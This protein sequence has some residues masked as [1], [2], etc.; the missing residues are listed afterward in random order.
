[1]KPNCSLGFVSAIVIFAL[2]APAA[3]AVVIATSKGAGADAEVRDHQPATNLGTS[4]ELGT[5]ILDNVPPGASDLNDRFSAMYMKF[6]ITGQTAFANQTTSVR[7]TYRNSNLTP[8]R[9]HDTTPPGNNMDFRTGLAFY[10]L[11]RDHPGNN[12]SEATITYSNAPGIAS[13][14]NNGTKDY[15]F[16][17]PDGGGPL[18]VPLTPLGIA[19]FPEVPP[20][21]RLPVGGGLV[22]SSDALNNFLVS[23][24]NAGKTSVTI[25]AGIVHDGKIPVTEW[26]NFNYLFV[27]KEQTTLNTDVGYDAD[28]T[29]PSNPLGSPWS[30]ASNAEN[31]AGFSPFS[32]QL[33][34][35]T[36]GDFNSDGVVNTAD[37]VV[38][39]ETDG[40]LF[41]YNSWRSNY[42]NS[43]GGAT[44]S[45]AAAEVPE[46]AAIGLWILAMTLGFPQ[47]RAHHIAQQPR[48]LVR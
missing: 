3:R 13:D 48:R 30:A 37:Y 35:V 4:T 7:L 17:D 20:Q 6:D 31:A 41:G 2:L 39:R 18:R 28:T 11:D 10:G 46:P 12:W 32:P 9:V 25:V 26:K 45:A 19:L 15:D 14:G 22:F 23:S 42:G 34:F 16:V 36:Q 29:N 8:N 44:G 38:W 24:L 27:P 47:R 21:N 1:M 43:G 40:T 33:I 5:R